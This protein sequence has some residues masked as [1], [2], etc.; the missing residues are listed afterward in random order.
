MIEDA[1]APT[2]P[3]DTV[4]RTSEGIPRISI[5]NPIT[6]ANAAD[7]QTGTTNT[8]PP[9]PTPPNF[10][11]TT[12]QFSEGFVDENGIPGDIHKYRDLYNNYVQGGADPDKATAATK[13][14]VESDGFKW[15]DLTKATQTPTP[16]QTPNA[17]QTPPMDVPTQDDIDGMSKEFVRAE[18][19]K[20]RSF[21]G[22]TDLMAGVNENVL[23]DIINPAVWAAQEL[24]PVA[25]L[26][27]I[28]RDYITGTNTQDITGDQIFDFMKIN[29][30]TNNSYMNEAGQQTSNILATSMAIQ[31][32]AMSLAREYLSAGV[33]LD[34]TM[35]KVVGMAA[36]KYNEAVS[37]DPMRYLASEM[38]GGYGSIVGSEW[39]RDTAH[40]KNVSPW[41]EE[42]AATGGAMGGATV[43]A[44][45][46]PLALKTAKGV[47]SIPRYAA[48]KLVEA[49][50]A[51]AHL[52]QGST[53]EP[54][55]NLIGGGELNYPSLGMTRKAPEVDPD[56]LNSARNAETKARQA[57]DDVRNAWEEYRR[58]AP[59]SDMQE[60]WGYKLN[61][62]QHLETVAHKEATD[63][64]NMVPVEARGRY[65]RQQNALRSVFAQT[66]YPTQYAD[67]QI[68][69]ETTRLDQIAKD[70][71]AKLSPDDPSLG[72]AGYSAKISEGI[73]K[74]RD[75]AKGMLEKYW[76]RTPINKEMPRT[77]V[78][79]ALDTYARNSA[80]MPERFR[81]Q[82]EMDE[83]RNQFGNIKNKT[84]LSWLKNYMTGL[85]QD[86]DTAYRQGNR[87]A[88]MMY[89]KLHAAMYDAVNAAFPDNVPLKQAREVSQHYFK[90]FTE[91][92][93]GQFLQ[94]KRTGAPLVH[95]EDVLSK[96]INRARG[97][98]DLSKAIAW[99]DKAGVVSVKSPDFVSADQKAAIEGL[100]GDVQG[101]IRAHL[102]QY[103]NA[104]G[105]DPTK[106]ASLLN[107]PE[108]QKKIAA[109]TPAVADVQQAGQELAGVVQQRRALEDSTLAKYLQ[110][111]DPSVAINRLWANKDPA[112][113]AKGLID[114]VPGVGGFREDP[115]AMQG[116]KGA[117]LDKLEN[118]TLKQ[119]HVL[120]KSMMVTDFDAVKKELAGQHGRL[121]QTVLS[122]DEWSRL[123]A[124][125]DRGIELEKA[126]AAAE[127]GNEAVKWLA[128]YGIL[129]F[130]HFLPHVGH[131]GQLKQASLLSSFAGN[132]TER[133]LQN[134]PPGQLFRNALSNPVVEDMMLHNVPRDRLEARDTAR[135]IRRATTWERGAMG[136]YDN[137]WQYGDGPKPPH[138]QAMSENPLYW[139]V[140]GAQASTQPT[141]NMQTFGTN[142]G[143]IPGVGQMDFGDLRF[144]ASDL[145][146]GLARQRNEPPRSGVQERIYQD[147]LKGIP[148]DMY[149]P[150][151]GTPF[152]PGDT[153]DFNRKGVSNETPFNVA[154]DVVKG[155]WGP[156]NAVR[157]PTPNWENAITKLQDLTGGSRDQVM[158]AL[159]ASGALKDNVTPMG[160]DVKHFEPLE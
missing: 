85:H 40:A 33:P 55:A 126:Q 1:P 118:T 30:Y 48:R 99:L 18:L 31:F 78:L 53:I 159:K 114:G 150:Q 75:Q 131:G 117:L 16:T 70:A 39:A 141:Q 11:D 129:H 91:S 115:I 151:R 142:T 113:F 2:N 43:G 149:T 98:D 108:F 101:G 29:H 160:G 134:M 27:R 153:I 23:K 140:P 133:M 111:G 60:S 100:Q 49:V 152:N 154:G 95:P 96:L 3:F 32:G 156:T 116:L 84:S 57:S 36:Q 89:D 9:T 76:D 147:Y 69:G 20:Q 15:D 81:P 62:L 125:V 10:S 127:K 72:T 61:D 52:M 71:F 12:P 25:K 8:A 51:T 143:A 35:K 63:A 47:I 26:E 7:A 66:T 158:R 46:A 124:L 102:Q 19:T 73:W 120:D 92:E 157:N 146:G 34:A 5:F 45:L 56:V 86:A 37:K 58:A 21:G 79:K 17:A 74:L 123:N 42:L 128:Q 22:L 122:S 144:P 83:I 59:G 136:Y 24:N 77:Q 135:L 107:S 38:M 87:Q 82:K 80:D 13:S 130:Q 132:I 50:N 145:N 104:I 137:W 54:L 44:G 68:I 148:K 139:V 138:N 28:G 93:L 94:D 155:P 106:A 109:F 4:P 121:L 65:S 67:S 88:G 119:I 105:Y 103:F 14:Q 97:F 112:A 64:W 110:F 41:M 6:P 90:Y